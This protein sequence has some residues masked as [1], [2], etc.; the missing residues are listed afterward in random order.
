MKPSNQSDPTLRKQPSL[1][2]DLGTS[3]A[4]QVVVVV[5]SIV[6]LRL[7]AQCMDATQVGEF[8]LVRRVVVFLAPLLLLGQGVG[9]PRFLG[10][11]SGEP[12]RRA[13]FAVAGWL[14]VLPAT[15]AAGSY[16]AFFP[17]ATA[18]LFFGTDAAVEL[19]RPLAWLVVGNQVFLV[20]YAILRGELRIRAANALQSLQIGIL[21]IIV[22]LLVGRQ[23]ALAALWGIALASLVLATCAAAVVMRG[24]IRRIRGATLRRGIRTLAGYG[25]VRV[26]GDLAVAGLYALGPILTAHTLDLRTA[27]VLAVGL[28]LVTALSAAFT[29][30]GLVLLPRLSGQLAGPDARHVRERLPHFV[31]AAMH[32]GALLA[33]VGSL[34]GNDALRLFLGPSFTFPNLA[35]GLLVLGAAGNVLFVALRSVLDADTAVPLNAIHAIVALG[36]LFG[37]WALSQAVGLDPLLGICAAVAT[38]FVGLGLLTLVAVARRFKLAWGARGC[39]KLVAVVALLL[40]VGV[41]LH[42]AWAAHGLVELVAQQMI[43]VAVW[44]VALHVLRVGWVREAA[45]V[46]A[47]RRVS[48]ISRPRAT[49]ASVHEDSGDRSQPAVAPAPAASDRAHAASIVPGGH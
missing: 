18:T 4:S 6:T 49:D 32:A 21:P 37:G 16:L 5:G 40:A 31:G 9:L 7:A 39:V 34:F 12:A 38:S 47:A 41:L 29:P 42:G 43:L 14:V 3:L 35:L 19:S 20:V 17:R 33:V 25:L 1:L 11:E 13:A 48:R 15:I 24:A 23:G 10:R 22:M 2:S 26:P 44:M 46:L 45:R 36:L 28:S 27:G 30:L 8:A